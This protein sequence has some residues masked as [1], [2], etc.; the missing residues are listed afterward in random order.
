MN[1]WTNEWM[2]KQKKVY[3]ITIKTKTEKK[4]HL[5]SEWVKAQNKNDF[6]SWAQV[7]WKK[8]ND[9]VH[10]FNHFLYPTLSQIAE[11]QYFGKKL[12][13]NFQLK[14]RRIQFL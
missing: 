4:E 13:N 2:N 5:V 6:C 3:N 10:L 12:I 8:W 14:F 1:E 11:L 7:E 9:D